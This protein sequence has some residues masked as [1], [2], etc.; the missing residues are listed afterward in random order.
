MRE[1]ASD[2]TH[3]RTH[4]VTAAYR[5]HRDSLEFGNEKSDGREILMV[6][7]TKNASS[8]DGRETGNNG[9]E[10]ACGAKL[11]RRCRVEKGNTCGATDLG[12]VNET[13]GVWYR[14]R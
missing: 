1:R 5:A 6:K 9:R 12:V 7:S 13:R 2:G 14:E 8:G 3:A 10:K 4:A 11:Q